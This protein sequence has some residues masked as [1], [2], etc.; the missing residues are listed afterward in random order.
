MTF[1]HYSLGTKPQW[2]ILFVIVFLQLYSI[3]RK[4]FLKKKTLK[5]YLKVL[6]FQQIFLFIFMIELCK[7]NKMFDKILLSLKDYE[8]T[9][10]VDDFQSQLFS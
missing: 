5:F 3:E 6:I 10:P 4:H 9:C 7:L 2:L 1:I 8:N